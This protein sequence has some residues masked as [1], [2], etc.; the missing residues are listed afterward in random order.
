MALISKKITAIE[1]VI[2]AGAMDPSTCKE[3]KGALN[4][5]KECLIRLEENPEKPDEGIVKALRYQGLEQS[6]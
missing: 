2:N 5:R 4:E 3:L 1:K 6:G